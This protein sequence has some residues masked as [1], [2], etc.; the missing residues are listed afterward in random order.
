MSNRDVDQLIA[1]SMSADARLSCRGTSTC[2]STWGSWCPM[3][4]S[5]AA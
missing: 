5:A 2:Q 1:E 3:V 4:T